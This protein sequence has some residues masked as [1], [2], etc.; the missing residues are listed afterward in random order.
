ML[1]GLSA[2]YRLIDTAAHYESEAAVGAALS[3]ARRRGLTDEVR[4]VTKVWFD[5][6][7]FEVT[8]AH[9][10]TLALTT[11]ALFRPPLAL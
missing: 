6:M 7:G 1:D 10:A 2:G 4:T 8:P 11:R 5:D 9:P 3:E